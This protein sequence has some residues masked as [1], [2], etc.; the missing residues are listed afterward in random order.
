[1]VLEKADETSSLA[2][3]LSSV[4]ELIEDCID[5]TA[6][7]GVHWGTRSMLAFALS[8]FLELGAELELLRFGRNADLTEEQVSAL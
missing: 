5:T 8:H 2:V 3:A 7:N 1:M 4:A 6:A